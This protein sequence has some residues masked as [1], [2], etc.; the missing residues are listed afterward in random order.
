MK[1]V[2]INK[3]LAGKKLQQSV[4]PTGGN[5]TLA[6]ARLGAMYKCIVGSSA[7]YQAGI[8]THTSV[9]SAINACNNGETVLI[10]PGTYTETISV[11]NRV[12]IQGM[13]YDSYIN[14]TFTFASGASFCS[15]TR[16]RVSQFIFSAGANGNLVSGFW[17]TNPTDSGLGNNI[18]GVNIT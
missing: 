2:K 11:S 1:V 16:I 7:Q 18:T 6:Q 3:Y 5:D 15:L 10:L 17:S 8:A 4:A 9:Q 14:G 13:G 12:N